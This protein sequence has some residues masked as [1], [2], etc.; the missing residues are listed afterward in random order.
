MRPQ[1]ELGGGGCPFKYKIERV[2]YG[3]VRGINHGCFER[4]RQ[5]MGSSI[6][7]KLR[8]KTGDPKSKFYLIQR[9]SM[10]IER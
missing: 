6:G 4:R 10:A 8:W 2:Y 9:I 7:E 5:R 3:R 1:A